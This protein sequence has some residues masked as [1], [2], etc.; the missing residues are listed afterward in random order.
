[1]S[2]ESMEDFV[3]E[4][5][6]R[7][8]TQ[9]RMR[10]YPLLD[11]LMFRRSRRFAP[12][13]TLNGGPLAYQSTRPPQ[14]LTAAEEAALAFAACGITGYALGE[15]PYET[16]S[17][18][19]AGGGNI[20]KQ[21]VGRTSPSADALHAITVFMINDQ[22]TWM[23]RRPQD[24]P[25][26][27][28]PGLIEGARQHKLI[29]IHERSR[30]QIASKRLDVSRELPFV[31]PFNKWSA[32]VPGSTYFV[33][34]NELT[35]LYLNILLSCFSS[36]FNYFVVDERNGFRPAGIAKFAKSKG[37]PLH[38]DPRDGRFM[39]VGYLESWLFELASVELGAVVQN[40][41]LM[42]QALGIGGFPHFAGHPFGWTQALGFRMEEP[43]LSS[44]IAAGPVTKFAMKLLGKDISIP[45][46]VGLEHNGETLI[47]PYCS[48]YYPSMREAVLAF[49]AAKFAG[50]K[51]AFRD[52]GKNTAWLDGERV[53]A[54][55]PE[56]SA[57]AVEATI[58][59][60]EY[61]YQR[62]GRFTAACGPL[63]T[64]L[65]YQA[66]RLDPDFYQRFYRPDAK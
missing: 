38:D 48:P 32:N 19:D 55:I 29:E 27:E 24:F 33:P 64:T 7:A 17:V 1:M 63:R 30:V 60:C 21:F 31:P 14:P 62:Y 3:G 61:V 26:A 13:M 35:S 52:G 10:S 15:L 25:S 43:K 28:I 34:V 44:I 16:G 12:G 66:H 46:A 20:M 22:G 53:Q 9:E 51:G 8:D 6:T 50:G 4:D 57:T 65:A 18:P 23:L 42:S 45:F 40:L 54:G 58:A 41:G 11:A 37:G 36:D 39:T 59:Y 56:Y 47:K 5:G 2:S 49:V